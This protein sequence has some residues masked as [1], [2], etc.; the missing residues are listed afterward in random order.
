METIKLRA[1][2][3]FNYKTALFMIIISLGCLPVRA[4][5]EIQQKKKPDPEFWNIGLGLQI[6]KFQ[7]L[8]TSPLYYQGGGP[9]LSLTYLQ[10]SPKKEIEAGM[11]LSTGLYEAKVGDESTQSLASRFELIF[12]HLRSI[13][14]LSPGN[15]NTKVGVH[16]NALVNFRQNPFIGNNAIGFEMIHTLFG[17]IKIT[18][19]ISRNQDRT[20]KIGWLK[21]YQKAKVRDLSYRLNV[22]LMNNTYRNGYVYLN[23][24]WLLDEEEDLLDDHEYSF[25]SGARLGS[26][27][28]LTRYLANGN[29]IRWSLTSDI[30]KTGGDLDVLSS[31]QHTLKF[32]LMFNS[33]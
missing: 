14:R 16:A 1:P 4:Q 32:I 33:K 9:A 8:A 15:W 31:A 17:S 25:F 7:D 6:G 3:H 28:N 26:E 13:P 19:D 21:L 18:R 29:A 22:G 23:Q 30:Y 27:I 20:L 11:S 12:T 5:D 24:S 2:D 10:L